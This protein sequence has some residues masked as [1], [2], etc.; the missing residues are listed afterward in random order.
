MKIPFS[1]P[2]CNGHGTVSKPPWIAGDQMT[3]YASS[4]VLYTCNACDGTG[5]VWEEVGNDSTGDN[6][7]CQIS[8]R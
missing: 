2:V 1:C 4:S 6:Y 5:V 3:W 7:E 8:T